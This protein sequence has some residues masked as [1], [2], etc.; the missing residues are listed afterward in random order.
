MSELQFNKLQS[1]RELL[2]KM[3]DGEFDGN[4]ST[5]RKNISPDSTKVSG[6]KGRHS[7]IGKIV[8]ELV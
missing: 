8:K 7:T 1:K 6:V 4:M 2:F 5:L 3:L